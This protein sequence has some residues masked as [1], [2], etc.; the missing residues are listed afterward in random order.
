MLDLCSGEFGSLSE[1]KFMSIPSIE[2]TVSVDREVKHLGP[3]EIKINA[4]KMSG[5]RFLQKD[6]DGK[7]SNSDELF[8]PFQT[9]SFVKCLRQ[10][11]VIDTKC[12][13]FERNAVQ[14]TYRCF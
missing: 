10:C 13:N 6:V 1:N 4:G 12:N 9:T 2:K 8:S 5:T 11:S 14:N 3:P 7:Q